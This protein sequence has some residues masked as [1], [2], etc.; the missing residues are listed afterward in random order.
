MKTMLTQT[1]IT[2]DQDMKD[3]L[4]AISEGNP[5]ALFVCMEILTKT[6]T[7]DPQ[8]ALGGLG[9]LLFLD[10]QNIYGPRLWCLY[11]DVCK[12]NLSMMLMV[13]R[14]SQLGLIDNEIV[15]HAIDNRG[16]GLDNEALMDL[17]ELV[18]ERLQD[19]NL[20]V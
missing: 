14:A 2:E 11:K 15:N 13:I 8:N 6:S 3:M 10:T 5:G 17:S 12:Q 9:V 20:E 4:F 1:K 19:F 7:I 16:D 18:I